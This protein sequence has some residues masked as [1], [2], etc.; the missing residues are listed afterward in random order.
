[1]A[2]TISARIKIAYEDATSRNYTFNG[3]DERYVLGIK[4]KI[5]SINQAIHDNTADGIAFKTVF[6]SDGGANAIG[7]TEG[8]ITDTEQEVIYNAS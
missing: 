8:I 7:I 2:T 6:V 4:T 5:E 3:V 1:M